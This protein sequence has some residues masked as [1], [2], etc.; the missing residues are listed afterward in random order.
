MLTG[1]PTG[2][3]LSFGCELSEVIATEPRHRATAALASHDCC[4]RHALLFDEIIGKGQ[5]RAE[6]FPAMGG[7]VLGKLRDGFQGKV[8]IGDQVS[9]RQ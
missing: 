3:R 4:W 2:P 7:A 1:S 6:I 5:R 9:K 8:G